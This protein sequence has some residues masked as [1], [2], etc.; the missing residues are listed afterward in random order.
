MISP[1]HQL[2]N[3]DDSNCLFKGSDIGELKIL[4]ESELRK[5]SI[6][7]RANE[8]QIS[9]PKSQFILFILQRCKFIPDLQLFFNLNEDGENDSSKIVPL[10]RISAM[11]GDKPEDKSVHMLFFFL[12]ERLK[13][14]FYSEIL[15][16]S[17]SKKC[18]SYCQ[19]R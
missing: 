16:D 17:T 7:F 11:W 13:F 15:S 8:L 19:M 6:W 18:S 1:M 14:N 2:K 10:K 12:D 5:I 9:V 4:I 3:R